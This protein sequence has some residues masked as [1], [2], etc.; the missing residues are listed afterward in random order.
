MLIRRGMV[1]PR[2]DFPLRWTSLDTHFSWDVIWKMKPVS[3]RLQLT[4]A[5]LSS[6]SKS[7]SLVQE[8]R[9]GLRAHLLLVSL[10]SLS[11]GWDICS[12]RQED[13]QGESHSLCTGTRA[14]SSFFMAIAA[15]S[16]VRRGLGP[17]DPRTQRGKPPR[18]FLVTEDCFLSFDIW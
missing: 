8:V 16:G 9:P 11:W 12:R 18:K 5:F 1:N 17:T 14:T 7:Y 6:W 10:Q 4:D 3:L 15:Y 13:V 2:S